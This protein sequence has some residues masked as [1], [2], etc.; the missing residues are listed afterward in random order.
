MVREFFRVKY[1]VG[2]LFGGSVIVIGRYLL[3]VAHAGLGI[4]IKYAFILDYGTVISSFV[5]AYMISYIHERIPSCSSSFFEKILRFGMMIFFITLALLFPFYTPTTLY[6]FYGL[7]NVALVSSLLPSIFIVPI[8]YQFE[9]GRS[10]HYRGG[11]C[12]SHTSSGKKEE[13]KHKKMKRNR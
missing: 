6:E 10:I 9:P 8:L 5:I 12:A 13:H 4:D 3:D 11:V 7:I 1:F 2:A